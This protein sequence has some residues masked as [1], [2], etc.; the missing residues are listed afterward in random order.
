MTVGLSSNN[1]N[2]TVPASLSVAANQSGGTFTANVAAVSTDQTALLTASLNGGAKTF[3][4]T[5]SAP[6]Q[7]TSVSCSPSKLASNATSAARCR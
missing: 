4:L 5:A 1:A 7:L 6:A 3:T 2:V